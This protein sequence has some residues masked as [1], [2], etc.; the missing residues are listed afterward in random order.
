MILILCFLVYG[1]SLDTNGSIYTLDGDNT[2]VTK[3]IQGSS[4]STIVASGNGTESN[5][6]Q[7]GGS[8]GMFI[9]SSASNIWIADKINHRIV[10]WSSPTT[11]TVVCGSY[12]S[13]D[14][15]LSYPDGLFV[16]TSDSDTPY[17]A[18]SGNHRVQMWLPGATSGK[19]VAG[20]TSYY[21][22]GLNQL[23][24]P[25]TLIVDNDKN[26]FINDRYNN[27]ILKWKTGA[28][29]GVLIAGVLSRETAS[30]QLNNPWGINESCSH[31]TFWPRFS[32]CRGQEKLMHVAFQ[33]QIYYLKKK[34]TCWQLFQLHID[35]DTSLR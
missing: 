9:D 29:S 1:L 32:W 35:D 11:S 22:G 31:F 6:N 17:V 18:D 2:R 23:W 27:R 21:G 19:T 16:D 7:I 20:I 28:S 5:V 26:M 13:N 10:K 33:P 3:G 15:Q 14:N 12:G 25:K 30:N 24:F 8:F 34:I 4:S